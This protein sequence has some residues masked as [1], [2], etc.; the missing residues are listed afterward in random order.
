MLRRYACI[1]PISCNNIMLQYAQRERCSI[2]LCVTTEQT[3]RPTKLVR[4]TVAAPHAGQICSS[5]A[6]YIMSISSLSNSWEFFLFAVGFV[7][8]FSLTFFSSEKCL[9]KGYV[10]SVEYQP[11]HEWNAVVL[12]HP[13]IHPTRS[14]SLP[15]TQILWRWNPVRLFIQYHRRYRL[16]HAK[17]NYFSGRWKRNGLPVYREWSFIFI[18]SEKGVSGR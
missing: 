18:G 12:T 14:H 3:R 16:F 17:E 8:V 1:R 13:S 9:E 7:R 10:I 11:S 15:F 4:A 5:C 6:G 2:S